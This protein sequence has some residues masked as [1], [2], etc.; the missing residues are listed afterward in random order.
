[1]GDDVRQDMLALQIIQL[2]KDVMCD[3]GLNIYLVPYRVV[4]T[5]P[6]CGVIECIPNCKSRDQI[7]RQTDIGMYEY[8][9][10]TYGEPTTAAFQA[11]AFN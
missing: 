7:G 10:T 5:A 2:F 8:F 4:A 11:R 3:V 1:V 9:R 6:G